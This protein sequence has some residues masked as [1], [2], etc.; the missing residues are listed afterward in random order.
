MQRHSRA[1]ALAGLIGFAWVA[2]LGFA[3]L[4]APWNI[5]CLFLNEL[6]LG[7]V[8][9]VIFGYLEG[10]RGTELMARACAPAL[11]SAPAS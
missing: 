11:S 4:R 9:G 3:L 6:P 10:R 1:P 5:A 8:W 2:L 7:M